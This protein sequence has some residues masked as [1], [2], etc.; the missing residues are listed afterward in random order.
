MPQNEKVGGIEFEAEIDLNKFQADTKK[1]QQLLDKMN[2]S[3]KKTDKAL[4]DVEKSATGAGGAAGKAGISFKSLF[5]AFTLGNIASTAIM[6]AIRGVKDALVGAIVGAIDFQAQMVQVRKVTG[7]TGSEMRDLKKFVSEL[8]VETGITK[9][10]LAD[11]AASGGRLGIFSREGAKGLEDFTRV[12]ALSRIAMEDYAGSSEEASDKT[13]RLLNLF[14]LESRDSEVLLSIMNELSNTAAASSSNIADNVTNFASLSQTFGASKESLLALAA[15]MEEVGSE[16]EAFSTGFQSALFEMQKDTDKFAKFLGAEM[17]PKFKKTFAEDP[18]AAFAIFLDGLR[19][20]GRDIGSVLEGLGIGDR[21]LTRELAKL[22]TDKGLQRFAAN[23]KTA[24]E[25][26]RG[27]QDA[28]D[29]LGDSAS[30]LQQEFE[31]ASDTTKKRMSSLGEAV[32]NLGNAFGEQLQP[33]L[34]VVLEGLTIGF[35]AA[36][37]FIAEVGRAIGDLIENVI[38]LGA[39][40]K[41][42]TEGFINFSAGVVR[43]PFEFFGLAEKGAADLLIKEGIEGGDSA[44][45]LAKRFRDARKIVEETSKLRGGSAPLPKFGGGGVNIDSLDKEKGGGKTAEQKKE[46]KEL[47]K[48]QQEIDEANLKALKQRREILKE[49]L[50]VRKNTVGIS[51]KEERILKRIGDD[52]G[53]AFDVRRASNFKDLLEGMAEQTKELQDE[54]GGVT[55]EVDRLQGELEDMTNDSIKRLRDLTEQAFELREEFDARFGKE[56]SERVSLAKDI[57]TQLVEARKTIDELDGKSELDQSDME[58]LLAAKQTFQEGQKFLEGGAQFD[59]KVVEFVKELDKLANA[60]SIFEKLQLQFDSEKAIA[61]ETLKQK[62][63]E[64]ELSKE[65]EKAFQEERLEE[66]LKANENELTAAQVRHAEELQDK[67]NALQTELDLNRQLQL[68]ITNAIVGQVAIRNE[69]QEAFKNAEIARFDAIKQKALEAISAIKAAQSA[70]RSAA[71]FAH[72]GLVFGPGGPTEDRVPAMLSSG[73]FVV[74]AAAVKMHRPLLEAINNMRF[75]VPHFADGGEVT[76]NTNNSRSL[77]LTQH[78]HGDSAKAMANPR[79]VRWHA[80]KA[81]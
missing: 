17:G 46:E 74:R 42:A 38:V 1:L 30:S 77:K 33:A 20:T 28:V 22:A 65:L 81:F 47:E 51:E 75:P 57:A 37:P 18:V 72:G 73:E 68:D 6:K 64:I 70:S 50:E 11:I 76:N 23:L 71:K 19:Q 60:K 69:A 43:K 12:I 59:P 78:F 52:A 15:T 56:G 61:E 27:A 3:V 14:G 45:A 39:S 32:S 10:E 13:A 40:I 62:E 63:R 35:Q 5:G 80:R 55:K 2:P 49:V 9:A 26:S 36:L 16:P 24:E 8:G 7:A 41:D 34:D 29:G 48:S 31:R 4:K 67:R 44:A 66:F 58:K 21:R 53:A 79:M 54:F 25:A